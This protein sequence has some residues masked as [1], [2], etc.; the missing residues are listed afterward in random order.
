MRNLTIANHNGDKSDDKENSIKKIILLYDLINLPTYL[1]TNKIHKIEERKSPHKQNSY[2][3][4][5]IMLFYEKRDRSSIYRISNFFPL[6][7]EYPN[8]ED[9]YIFLSRKSK[10][11]YGNTLTL[12]QEK[13]KLKYD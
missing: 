6:R 8:M 10:R 9:N 4:D 3:V 13:I 2:I 12:L 1:K 7:K 5:A 11:N